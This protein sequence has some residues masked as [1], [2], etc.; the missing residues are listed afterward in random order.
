MSERC[1]CQG[2]A[3]GSYS[4]QDALTPPWGGRVVGIDRCIRPEI[5]RLWALGVRTVESCCGHQVTT[6]YIIARPEFDSLMEDS[7]Y[8]RDP[9]APHAFI[10][11]RGEH[12]T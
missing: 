10:W 11:P 7:G 8:R 9:C 1:T 12:T 3:M 2:V 5:E 4:N 6:G